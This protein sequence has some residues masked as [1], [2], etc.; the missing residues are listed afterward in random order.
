MGRPTARRAA[1]SVYRTERPFATSTPSPQA[2]GRP[3]GSRQWSSPACWSLTPSTATAGDPSC[4][5]ISAVTQQTALLPSAGEAH[6]VRRLSAVGRLAMSESSR[7][8]RIQQVAQA[9]EYFV[10]AEVNKRGAFAV[11]F[12]GRMPKID[13][14]A[15]NR[16][17]S[18]RVY[19]QV[20]TKRG[21]KTWHS[22]IV[23]SERTS[24]NPRSLGPSCEYTRSCLARRAAEGAVNTLEHHKRNTIDRVRPSAQSRASSWARW[25]LRARCAL[26]PYRLFTDTSFPALDRHG[27]PRPCILHVP[28]DR[29]RTRPALASHRGD[30]RAAGIRPL[31]SSMLAPSM[32][33][34]QVGSPE[35][36]PGTGTLLRVCPGTPA[37]RCRLC[38]RHR[39]GDT[40]H[41]VDWR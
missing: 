41:A 22:S 33:V 23:G 30:I 20:K 5:T 27:P 16:D 2:S 26:S 4:S 21:G 34:A 12:A 11:P 31:R 25:P 35:S 10:L 15:C 14:I 39:R 18:R 32:P 17:Q 13:I 37:R 7:G 19:I 1:P 28:A 9:G 40:T 24:E 3:A 38:Q 6:P 8:A 36:C 29:G